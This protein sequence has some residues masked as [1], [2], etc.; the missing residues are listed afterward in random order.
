MVHAANSGMRRLPPKFLYKSADPMARMRAKRWLSTSSHGNPRIRQCAAGIQGS[1]HTAV[2]PRHCQ[3]HRLS[4][5]ALT[6]PSRRRNA[7]HG[8]GSLLRR[9]RAV[10]CRTGHCLPARSARRRPYL[11]S[12]PSWSVLL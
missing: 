2:Q 5:E 11:S 3:H 7:A 9:A 8:A 1:E 6:P 12:H 4:T 10:P